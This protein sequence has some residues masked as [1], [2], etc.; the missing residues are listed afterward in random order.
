[1]FNSYVPLCRPNMIT[2]RRATKDDFNLF[3]EI[4]LKSLRDSPDAFGSTYET[5]LI[6]DD[7]CWI[8]QLASTTSGPF[9]NTHFAFE[10]DKC[11]GIA[12]LYRQED[13]DSGDIIMMW[14]EPD[15]RGSDAAK[16]LVESL[17][18]WAKNSGFDLI[19]LSVTDTNARAI[20]FYANCGFRPT[21]D[22]VDVDVS[23]ELRGIR[24]EIAVQ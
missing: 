24:M 23:R 4:R 6:R 12:A 3:K 13:T 10:M 20:Q 7:E 1:M 18:A 2:C 8:D 15:H 17:L 16:M 22:T 19:G 9:R 5:N 11:I 21:G 14:G